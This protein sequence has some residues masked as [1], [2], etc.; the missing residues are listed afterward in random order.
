MEK[1]QHGGVGRRAFLVGGALTTLGA[2]AATSA[3]ASTAAPEDAL[4]VVTPEAS[5]YP[6]L[7]RGNN[8]RWVAAPQ[9]VALP[10]NT[11]QVVA[12]VQN[13]VSGRKRITVRSGGHCYE[14][15]VYNSAT[16]VV[17]DLSQLNAVGYDEQRRAFYVEP[18][19]TVLNVVNTLYRKWGVTIPAGMCYSVGMG[20]HV[21]GGGWGLL[22]RELGLTVD[23]LHAV[24]VVTVGADGVARAVVATNSPSD[25]NRELWWAHTGGGG[26]SFGV[27]TR[28]WFRTPGATGDPGA[29]LPSPP[30]EVYLHALSWKWADMTEAR[31]T[32]L[33]RNYGGWHE[34]NSAPGGEYG[35]LLSFLALGHRSSDRIALTT[36]M[37]ASA[38]DALAKLERFV[39]EVTDGVDVAA[40]PLNQPL[41]EFGPMAEQFTAQRLPWLQATTRLGVTNSMLTNPSLRGDF[42][43]AFMRRGLPDD[44]IAALY[45][46]LSRTDFANPNAL[47][48]ASSYGGRVNAV[49][50]GDTATPH[51]D[52]VIKL[53]Y[54][55]Y[56]P[57]PA[58]DAANVAWLRDIYED[59]YR[60]T[61]G[62]PVPNDVTDGCYVNYADI[63]LNDPARNRSGRSWAELYFG[64][65]YPRLQ[66][67]KAKWDPLDVFRHGQSVELPP[68]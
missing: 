9:A 33:V 11:R 22:C 55:A 35:G 4:I 1:R 51:R 8:Q 40:V 44:Q 19:A 52:S 29:L 10:V 16:Q 41:G 37:T 46:H 54:Q 12:A 39:A 66:R 38:P 17:I 28:F 25:P 50:P 30:A 20:G 45:R 34:R 56:W 47:V 5:R 32:R 59:V 61:G 3:P 58:A 21:T 23:Y 62:V 42:K 43:S 67:V 13:A 7:V 15:F 49:A 6:D 63:D 48:V 53:L 26:G 14:D 57:D 27:V 65:N 60:T 31:F 64:A 36:Q 68:R 2:A 18:G 24:E